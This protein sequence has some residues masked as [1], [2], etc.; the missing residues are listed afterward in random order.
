[1]STK[2]ISCDPVS[3]DTP[4]HSSN[5]FPFRTR[6][7]AWNTTTLVTTQS[8]NSLK[9]ETKTSYMSESE[10]CFR[11]DVLHCKGRWRYDNPHSA[12]VFLQM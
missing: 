1:M 9:A 2:H 4:T 6:H 3:K 12:L 10:R 11:H 7:L 8:H 5:K